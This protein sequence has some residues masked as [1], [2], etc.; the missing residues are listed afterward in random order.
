LQREAERFRVETER[1]LGVFDEEHAAR[2]KTGQDRCPVHRRHHDARL[3]RDDR[4]FQRRQRYLAETL[5]AIGRSLSLF[6][7]S[8][9]MGF[10][11]IGLSFLPFRPK[12]GSPY[13]SFNLPKAASRFLA[14][15][16]A[17]K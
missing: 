10:S 5:S 13:L 8:S 2:E 17:R 3:E 4:W 12:T 14:S 7:S 1:I 11:R 9:D 6:L 16:S 15:P